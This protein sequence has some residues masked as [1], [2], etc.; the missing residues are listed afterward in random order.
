MGVGLI[1]QT[2]TARKPNKASEICDSILGPLHNNSNPI[3]AKVEA[4]V[5]LVRVETAYLCVRCRLKCGR[6]VWFTELKKL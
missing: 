3:R 5:T 2:V 1:K 6:G 4:K